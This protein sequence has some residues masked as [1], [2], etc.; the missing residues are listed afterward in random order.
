MTDA[1]HEIVGKQRLSAEG[2]AAA[3]ANGAA[4][5]LKTLRDLIDRT[6]TAD[7]ATELDEHLWGREP[8]EAEVARAQANADR[9]REA[10]LR[11]TLSDALPERKSRAPW[12][13]YPGRL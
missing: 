10:A 5:P 4:L 2:L 3:L 13:Q 7:P 6:L 11:R 8:T 12:N 9:A 1:L